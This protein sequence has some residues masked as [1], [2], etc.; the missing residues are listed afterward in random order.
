MKQARPQKN[1]H[2]LKYYLD[3]SKSDQTWRL[4]DRETDPLKQWKLYN[5]AR[6]VMLVRTQNPNTTWTLLHADNKRLA[7]LNIIKNSLRRLHYA[8]KNEGL[9]RSN[10]QIVFPYD[11]SN[12]ENGW[13]AK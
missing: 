5:V 10:P 7:R 1:G 13:L 2:L 3:I 8:D 6:N 4:K 11:V 12:R 9:I